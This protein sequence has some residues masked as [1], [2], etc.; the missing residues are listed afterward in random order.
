MK[1]KASKFDYSRAALPRTR[2]VQFLD[3]FKMNY[4]LILKCGLMLLLFFLPMIAFSLFADFFYVSLMS[5]ATEEIEQTQLVYNYLLNGGLI[6]CSLIAIIGVTGV[7]YVLRNFIWGEGIFFMNDF[8]TGIKQ[9]AGK[10]VI[11][12]M[13]FA[14]FY[15]L[16]YVI[17]SLFPGF[18]ISIVPIVLFAAIFLPVYF[19]IILL[20][21]LYKSKWTVLLRNGLFFYIKTIGWSLLGILMPLSLV[22]LIFIPFSF[23]W[24]KYL[25]LV[26]FIIFVFPIIFLIMVLYST[27]KFDESINKENYPDYYLRGLNHD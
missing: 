1:R 26:L 16:G 25:V 4:L 22:G 14:I 13:I 7:V 27:A 9:N 2:H 24:I 12:L 15:A 19:W 20:N 17:F 10:N 23:I 21:N 18:I 5:N 11:F 8:G 3:C 6:L